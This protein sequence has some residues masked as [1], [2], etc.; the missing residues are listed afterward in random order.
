MSSASSN[1]LKDP[2]LLR[3]KG[4]NSEPVS[5]EVDS[6]EAVDRL[7]DE[8]AQELRAQRLQAIRKAVEA[9]AY[10]SDELLEKALERMR[11]K[12]EDDTDPG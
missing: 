4:D 5:S 8:E 1:R 3:G 12:L 7:S 11:R 9:G 6:A 2:E 10:D